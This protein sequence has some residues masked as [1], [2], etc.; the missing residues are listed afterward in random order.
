MRSPLPLPL[1]L[2]PALFL[3]SCA[4][5]QNSTAVRD[6]VYFMPS[7]APLTS[8]KPAPS[9]EEQARMEPVQPGASGADDYY[10]PGVARDQQRRGFY[11]M[12]YNDPYFYNYGRFGFGTQLG[13][14]SGWNG[15]GWGMGMGWGGGYG[16]NDPWM[17]I[18]FGWG[19]PYMD[20]WGCN[21]PWGWHRPWYYDP[22]GPGPYY[23]PW[24][25]CWSC[26]SPVIIG[27][28]RQVVV[29]PRTGLGGGTRT[30]SGSQPRVVSRDPAGLRP[31]SR[32]PALR[33]Q[34]R[35]G[36]ST[37]SAGDRAPSDRVAPNTRE[38]QRQPVRTAPGRTSPV[39]PGIQQ[40]PP[41]RNGGGS[42]M[43]SRDGGSRSGGSPGGGG[44][45]TG[46]ARPR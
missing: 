32:T 39:R 42:A 45:R 17:S 5:M 46:G 27:G 16:W 36:I 3:A 20:P 34:Q 26:Y 30:V 24:G 4:S 25:G 44:S 31:A 10:D 38:G 41:T 7:D 33:E 9:P 29:R 40:G 14:Q 37:R 1:L 43:P 19:S 2:L 23:S 18:N 11:D 13:W 22:W 12:A 15:P 8:T 35:S 28:G 21:R 6:D